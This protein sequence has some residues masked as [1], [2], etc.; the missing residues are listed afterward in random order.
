ML[1]R[2]LARLLYL[3]QWDILWTQSSVTPTNIT[4]WVWFVSSYNII[5]MWT[6]WEWN[7]IDLRNRLINSSHLKRNGWDIVWLWITTVPIPIPSA[8]SAVVIDNPATPSSQEFDTYPFISFILTR[9]FLLLDRLFPRYIT[10]NSISRFICWSSESL[11]IE[12]FSCVSNERI[13]H[14]PLSPNK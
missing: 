3:K 4:S 8:S 14:I 1:P 7:H 12:T 11:L 10:S 9:S 2:L 5:E 13:I 6:V